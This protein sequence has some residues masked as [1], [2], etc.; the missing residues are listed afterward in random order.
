MESPETA[1]I[2]HMKAQMTR[3]NS[4]VASTVAFPMT[5][6]MPDGS[7]ETFLNE[8]DLPDMNLMPVEMAISSTSIVAQSHEMA[9]V[10]VRFGWDSIPGVEAGEGLAWWCFLNQG[11]RWLVSWRQYLGEVSTD[12]A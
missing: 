6:M 1:A 5:Q 7:K 10:E 8:D 12:G 4:L 11:S 9:I 3:D 2:E